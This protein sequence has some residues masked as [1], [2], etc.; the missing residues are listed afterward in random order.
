MPVAGY[1]VIAEPMLTTLLN[2]EIQET[3]KVVTEA[4]PRVDTH[5]TLILRAVNSS[6]TRSLLTYKFP[7]T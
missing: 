6:N 2:V 3:N 1:A 7:P 5:V 4:I